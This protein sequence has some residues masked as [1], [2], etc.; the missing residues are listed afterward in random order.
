MLFLIGTKEILQKNMDY[1]IKQYLVLIFVRL[2]FQPYLELQLN[3]TN[4]KGR[5]TFPSLYFCTYPLIA[6]SPACQHFQRKK[7]L[8]WLFE[9]SDT[10]V[11]IL[12]VFVMSY[13]CACYEFT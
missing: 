6:H 1:K 7:H 10:W 11:R 12:N 8:F 5:Q 3:L 13:D 2:I 4:V 9:N